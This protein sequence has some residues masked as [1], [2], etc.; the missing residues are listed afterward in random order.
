MIGRI[1][2]SPRRSIVGIAAQPRRSDVGKSYSRR[3]SLDAIA[4][5][6]RS[7]CVLASSQCRRSLD[8]HSPHRRPKL[9]RLSTECPEILSRPSTEPSPHRVAKS[10]GLRDNL[11]AAHPCP[12]AG[13]CWPGPHLPLHSLHCSRPGGLVCD[14][15]QPGPG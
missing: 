12:E 13:H 14:F 3:L 4:S 8:A 6:S 9:D 11:P 7:R 10:T 5:E 15:F 1:A 2:A